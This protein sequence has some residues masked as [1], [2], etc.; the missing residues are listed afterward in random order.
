MAAPQHYATTRQNIRAGVVIL[1]TAYNSGLSSTYGQSAGPFALY[2]LDSATSVKPIGW[3]IYNPAAP[4]A[5]TAAMVNRWV[6]INGA[7]GSS[8][9]VP[10]LGS[11]IGKNDAEYWAVYLSQATDQTLSNY[12]VLLLNPAYNASLSGA[13]Q[14]MLMKFVDQGGILWIDPAGTGGSIAPDDNFPLAFLLDTGPAGNYFS[15]PFNPLLNTPNTITP[16][17]LNNLHS[18]YNN[19]MVQVPMG[20]LAATDPVNQFQFALYQQ[21]T[22]IETG[23]GY[24]GTIS[25]AHVGAG[26]IVVTTTGASILLNGSSGLGYQATSGPGGSNPLNAVQNSAAKLAV[27]MI[28]SLG[29][30]PEVGT[31]SRKPNSSSID[32]TAPVANSWSYGLGTPTTPPVLYKGVYVTVVGGQVTVFK[33]QLGKDLDG[34]GNPD[35]GLQDYSLGEPYDI[36]WQSTTG[37]GQPVPPLSAPTCATVP[38]ATG[39]PVDQVLVVDSTGTLFAYNLFPKSGGVLQ[40]SEAAVYSVAPPAGTGTFVTDTWT[41]QTGNSSNYTILPNAPT[42]SGD[43][44]FIADGVSY[45]TTPTGRVWIADLTAGTNLGGTMTPWYVGGSTSTRQLPGYTASPTIGY[46]PLN[47]GSN[48]YDRVIYGPG[49]FVPSMNPTSPT[50]G[51]DSLW[52]GAKN[53]N[54]PM[55]TV[56]PTNVMIETRAGQSTLPIYFP[57]SLTGLSN[58]Q[59]NLLPKVTLLD[60][61]GDAI[62]A[63]ALMTAGVTISDFSTTGS[64]YLSFDYTGPYSTVVK[65]IRVDYTI[66]WS[67]SPSVE[68]ATIERGTLEYPIPQNNG[69]VTMTTWRVLGNIA[70]TPAGTL[71]MA[72]TDPTSTPPNTFTSALPPGNGSLYWVKEDQGKGLF[73]LTGRFSLFSG[74]PNLNVGTTQINYPSVFSN[75]D[76]LVTSGPLSANFSTA[77]GNFE[78]ASGPSVRG[79]QVFLTANATSNY[80]GTIPV[81]C[82]IVMAFAADPSSQVLN[83]SSLNLSSGFTLTQPDPDRS[84]YDGFNVSSSVAPSTTKSG[85][86]FDPTTGLVTITNLST[87]TNGQISDSLSLSE[88]ILINSGAASQ[89]FFEPNANGG[90]TWSPL[91]WYSVFLGMKSQTAPLAT[92][93]TVFFGGSSTLPALLGTGSYSHNQA[94]VFALNG[95]IASNDPSLVSNPTDRTWQQ[96]VPQIIS[97]SPFQANPDFLMPQ[98]ANT[99]LPGYVIRLNQTVQGLSTYVLGLAGGGTTLAAWGDAGLYGMSRSDFY[100]CDQG[101]VVQ[102]DSNGNALFSTN[103][104]TNTGPGG[105][106]S[107]GNIETI[108]RPNRAYPL[109]TGDMLVVD[110]GGNRVIK[111]DDSGQEERSITKFFP[112]LTFRPPGF[113]AGEP[114]TLKGPMDSITYSNYV[115]AA[116]NPLSNP[117]PLEYWTHYLIADSGH[118]RLVEVVDRYQADPVSYQIGPLVYVTMADPNSTNV[119]GA[120]TPTSVPQ[121]GVLLWQ[122]PSTMSGKN[123]D[124]NSVSRVYLGAGAGGRYVYVAGIGSGQSS[125]VNAG[126]DV[127]SSLATP[128]EASTGNG[129]VVIYD[130]TAPNGIEIFNR[131]D[132]PS[133][134]GTNF[135]DPATNAFDVPGPAAQLG[136]PL[137]G[138]LAV[139]AKNLN[140]NLLV[141]VSMSDGVYEFT[142]SDP[143]GTTDDLGTPDWFINSAAYTALEPYSAGSTYL[144]SSNALQ[145]KPT[146]ARRLDS[147]E[148]IVVNGYTGTTANY[149]VNTNTP[150]QGQ[151]YNG[152]VL[153]LN[154][155]NGA[156]DGFLLGSQNLGFDFLSIHFQLPSISGTRDLL[157]PVFADRR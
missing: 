117:Q 33:A 85:I 94:V 86:F 82:T 67:N 80:N 99:T 54:P 100:V 110:T 120:I 49:I 48:G 64:G 24:E 126:L 84:T 21:V 105:T 1:D 157:A 36:I 10:T 69:A 32:V 112:D 122:S 61:N 102:V 137:T 125:R 45:G 98:P 71:I 127:P 72:V 43:L 3:N 44:A 131:Y 151:T 140:G 46:I 118:Q 88:P 68:T 142:L 113:Q 83:L 109:N 129:G 130:P 38:D 152:E 19:A 57:T 65:G 9:N 91:Q 18:L 40:S 101:R 58:A 156:P 146:Y 150:S 133:M 12:D 89:I 116:Q 81:P 20:S 134:T 16:G 28:S 70:L 23:G 50:P 78:W 55:V 123:F 111:M 51:F 42:V 39:E 115:L 13:E 93:S 121:A 76:P 17:D 92:G 79:S 37:A 11:P 97:W 139:T 87:Q 26:A 154:G 141:M 35:D 128:G 95:D 90:N 136:R 6:A 77:L 53:E 73:R 106:G 47:D 96:Q 34:D 56:N 4:G 104:S 14:A 75:N 143:P 62:S 124:Y 8:I 149:L 132:A 66:D 29:D 148:V 22:G 15:D 147:G 138:V 41:D 108:S 135:F 60:A 103:N 2:N 52:L 5:V 25:V 30:A 59:L 119:S 27:N 31:N 114:L 74:F 153:V 145:F 155:N 144:T 107:V 63:A 7:Y